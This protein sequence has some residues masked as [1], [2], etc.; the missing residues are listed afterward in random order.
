MLRI[1]GWAILAVGGGSLAWSL[2]SRRYAV[3][4]VGFAVAVTGALLGAVAGR[5]LELAER[6]DHVLED[7]FGDIE[8]DDVSTWVP[9][10]TGSLLLL[11]VYV[12]VRGHSRRRRVQDAAATR[13]QTTTPNDGSS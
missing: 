4:A 3:G 12:A 9:T 8:V 2:L 5:K 7:A 10:L 6:I 1:V 11:G 13:A